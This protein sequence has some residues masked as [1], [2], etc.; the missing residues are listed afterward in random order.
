MNYLNFYIPIRHQLFFWLLVFTSVYSQA[1]EI[2]VSGTVTAKSDGISLVGVSVL[3]SATKQVVTTDGN[4][5]YAIKAN[6]G[7]VLT[8]SY[9]G[10]D[11]YQQPV[12]GA[13]LNVEL[14]STA[15]EL[16][17]VVV[18]GYGTQ[19]RREITGSV[20]SVQ[21]EDLPQVANVSINNLLQGRAAGLN[22]NQKSAQPGGGLS[23]NVRGSDRPPLY[24]I[25]GVALFNNSPTEP[26]I[27]SKDLGFNGGVDRDPLSSINPSDIESIDVLKDASAAA[28]Y[29]A[30]AANGVVL[31]TTKKGKAGRFNTEYRGSFTTQ[32]PQAY[33]PFLNSENFMQ[34]QVRIAR[35]KFLFD[36]KLAPYGTSTTT[37]VFS[38]LFSQQA[39]NEAGAG[40][41]WL[42]MLIR[43][44]SINEHNLT[45]SGGTDKTRFY[46]S[47]NYYGNKA[48]IENSDFNR[49]TGRIN[50][51]QDLSERLKLFL[52][53]TVS[54]VN[55]NNAATGSNAGQ[56]EKY[57][58]LQAAYAFVPTVGIYDEEGNFSRSLNRLITNPA[59]FFIIDDRL[60]TNR[61]FLV[62]NL[63]VKIAEGLKFNAV[64]GI[65]RQS[66]KR[67]FFL[68]RRAQNSQLPEGMAQLASNSGHNYQAEGFATYN[69]AF[70]DHNFALLGGFGYYNEG[71][72]GFN[73]QAVGFFTDVLGSNN[74][75][76]GSD[77]ERAFVGS[78]K[79]QITKISQFSRI[80]YNYKAKYFLTFNIR[81]DGSSNFAENKKSGIFPGVSGGWQ[82]SDEAF[83]SNA[84]FLS[85]LKLRAGFGTSGNDR[86]L[87]A[88]ALYGTNGGTF[89]IGS[90]LNPSVALTQLANPNL[91]WETTK[92]T[93]VG[94]DWGFFDNRLT[95]A[96]DLFRTD[97]VDLIRFVDLPYNNA[98]SRFQTNLGGAHRS[99]G[100][101]FTVNSKNTTGGVKWETLFNLSKY[102]NRW[103]TRSPYDRLQPYQ[104]ADDGRNFVYGWQTNGII[105]TAADRPAYMPNANLGNL[106]F[107]DQNNDNKLDAAD[108][109]KIGNRDP[110]WIIG[111]GN[112]VSY[113][114]FDLNVFIYGRFNQYMVNNYSGFYDPNRIAGADAQNSLVGI[115]DVWSADRPNGT[116]PGIAANP[117]FGANPSGNTDFYQENVSFIRIRNVSLGYTIN[118]KKF[119][120]SARLFL[121]LQNLGVITNYKGYDPELTEVN[122]YP[123]AR[124][125]TFGINVNF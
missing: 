103:L 123:Q 121:D 18:V 50:L 48:V 39:I 53:L 106:I 87:N 118:A 97:N 82:I 44:G 62:P 24:V 78:N 60:I 22:L 55:S 35:D 83:L 86:N 108:V 1:Q 31:I 124:S 56:Q 120:R 77:R 16:N 88:E 125:T 57:N 110:K 117:Y 59:A 84:K 34:E 85:N 80:N 47:F 6:V 109:V 81:R 65:D 40:T 58:Q 14:S 15:N 115:A 8:F 17:E 2:A 32:K 122:P 96:I 89:L 111:L 26:A 113:K 49:Y 66:S 92:S 94:L 4:G 41:D 52:N 70:N 91:S 105:K 99:Q 95:G 90:T 38:P 28:I 27:G 67:D 101:E 19:T 20:V 73:L 3:N 23:I 21:T 100:I 68:P 11:T 33:F 119:V 25:D 72:E 30:A 29:G 116:L 45:M 75:G 43:D 46:S 5:K 13:T 114:N 93:N 104:S 12:K 107:V 9:I 51:Q 76:L 79:Y 64:G 7:H 10:F 71:S 61:F 36:K 74:V 102:V 69:K 112:T 98:V 42:G 37:D 63:E 54:Q